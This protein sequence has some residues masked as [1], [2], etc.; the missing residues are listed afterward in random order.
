[1]GLKITLHKLD[2]YYASLLCHESGNQWNETHCQSYL[3]VS[4]HLQFYKAF[5]F[6]FFEI[7]ACLVDDN[8]HSYIWV[9]VY[10]LTITT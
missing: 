7:H 10:Q 8:K 5:V 9:K 1:M 4:L 3:I 6:N 2:C